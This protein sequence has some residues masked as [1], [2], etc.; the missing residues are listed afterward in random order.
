MTSMALFCAA[1]VAA[2]NVL[3]LLFVARG[4]KTLLSNQVDKALKEMREE[5]AAARRQMQ[6][7]ADGAWVARQVELARD[8]VEG[9]TLLLQVSR[10]HSHSVPEAALRNLDF[11]GRKLEELHAALR[12]AT[13]P[14]PPENPSD[15]PLPYEFHASPCDR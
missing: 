8:H 14:A 13:S 10:L 11:L 9:I 15:H 4:L 12:P 1:L 7:S 2:L 3:M 5:G 6:L